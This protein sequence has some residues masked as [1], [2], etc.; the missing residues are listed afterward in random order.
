[1]KRCITILF[2]CF[3]FV[4]Q[5]QEDSLIVDSLITPAGNE[6][7]TQKPKEEIIKDSRFDDG[8]IIYRKAMLGGVGL[9]TAG[10]NAWFRQ[11]RSK[12]WY[13]S[14]Y[15]QVDFATMKHPKEIKISPFEG[16]RSYV[17]GKLNSLS[18]LRGTYG[19][20]RLL[21]E[22]EEFKG[23][24][25]GYNFSGGITLG[26]IKPTYLEVEFP[27][28][29]TG[30][31][32]VFERYDIEKHDRTKIIGGAP[33]SYGLGEMSI[34]PGIH[35]KG[36]FFVEY[37]SVYKYIRSI[38]VGLMADVF[39]KQV[40]IMAYSQNKALFLNFFASWQFGKRYN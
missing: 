35:L 9:H 19:Y 37:S 11:Y 1:M 24:Q 36:S 18:I 25:V 20:Q 22:K 28:V 16:E 38:E 3:S 30:E 40:P 8:R 29:L 2:I 33:L 15:W 13:K 39:Y 17:F 34:Q 6:V 7:S 5:A 4:I 23:V 14:Y 31:N 12:G 26:L 32:S 21:F 10:L 27:F